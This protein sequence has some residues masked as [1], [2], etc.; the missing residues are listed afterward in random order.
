MTD[1]H[2]IEACENKG[3]N[4]CASVEFVSLEA[5]CEVRYYAIGPS[6]MGM[7]FK[8]HFHIYFKNDSKGSPPQKIHWNVLL[9]MVLVNSQLGIG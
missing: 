9:M 4:D 3:K 6:Q 7:I 5:L 2:R 8:C 1:E